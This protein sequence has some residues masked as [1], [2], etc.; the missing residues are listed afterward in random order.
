MLAIVRHTWHAYLWAAAFGCLGVLPAAPVAGKAPAPKRAPA[1]AKNKAYEEI[2]LGPPDPKDWK[3]KKTTLMADGKFPEGKPGK[4]D[5]DMFDAHYTRLVKEMTHWN[6]RDSLWSKSREIKK[7]LNGF[8]RAPDKSIHAKLRGMMAKYLPIVVNGPKYNPYA[9]YNALLAYGELNS[10]EG[11]ISFNGCVPYGPALPLLMDVLK[12]KDGKYPAYLQP[13]ALAGLTRHILSQ[14][15]SITPEIR[16]ELVQVLAATLRKPVA[17]GDSPDVHNYTR[18]RASDLV[19]I[20][21]RWPEANNADVV[22]ALNQFAEDEDAPLDDRCEAIRTLGY[23]D[24]KSYPEKTVPAA[25]RTIALLAADVGRQTRAIEAAAPLRRP[26]RMRRPMRQR[27]MPKHPLR[28]PR[29]LPMPT[30]L[31]VQRMRKRRRLMRRPWQV[32]A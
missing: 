26:K 17:G 4:D 7:D 14:K 3:L 16:K 24:K 13:A 8:G 21:A 6:M 15:N 19:R 30:A 22:A 9:H 25:A 18:R 12:N 2:P 5:E 27:K 28:V 10:D 20:L 32:T 29:T 23:L 1:L 11:D 31:P